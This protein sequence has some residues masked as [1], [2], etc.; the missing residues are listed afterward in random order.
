MIIT[1]DKWTNKDYLSYLEGW[2]NQRLGYP[3]APTDS[4]LRRARNMGAV[5]DQVV[6]V[7]VPSTIAASIPPETRHAVLFSQ[8]HADAQVQ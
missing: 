6:G 4:D 8:G 5:V 3:A 7:S 2:S 1:R